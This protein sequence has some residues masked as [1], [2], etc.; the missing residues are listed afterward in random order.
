MAGYTVRPYRDSPA[1]R[2]ALFDFYRAAYAGMP[3]FLDPARFEWQ[4]VANPLVGPGKDYLFL[5]HDE[6]G[7]IVGQNLL[8]PYRLVIDGETRD[9]LCSTN[10]VVLPGLVGK[11]L[12]HLLI[13]RHEQEGEICFAVGITPA[14]SRAFQK[15]GWVPFDDARLHAQFRHPRPC[16]RFAKRGA[17]VSLLA[18]PAIHGLNALLA[19][20]RPFRV[21]S[22]LPD[23]VA[24]EIERFDPAW[25]PVWRECLAPHAI[26]FERR[27][28]LLNWKFRARTDVRHTA[29]LFRHHGTPV[30]Y[31]VYR[32][33]TNPGR[34]LT[35][36]RIVDLVYRRDVHPRFPHYLIGVARR[37]LAAQGVDG[38]VGI[39]ASGELR[40]A[41]RANGLVLTRPQPAIIRERHFSLAALRRSYP[42]RW[43][44]T[45]A[46][47]DLDN[48]W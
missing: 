3:E 1:A 2:A 44:I 23:V 32:L 25:D 16:L 14:S 34:G 15:R 24:E 43:Y 22:R 4:T 11:R 30:A 19:L 37:A 21:P 33:S 20:L 36:G 46:D 28:D 39:A 38:V 8:I 35:L 6:A 27:A 48:Y 18:A 29:L 42:D 47:S 45:L 10:L 31:L 7:K 40:A 41:Y 13:E 17:L 12:G 26:A 9:A 5:L